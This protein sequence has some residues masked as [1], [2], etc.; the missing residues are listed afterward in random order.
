MRL[1]ISASR[2]QVRWGLAIA[3]AV[4]VAA[5]T[6]VQIAKY[7]YGYRADWTR[8]WN[9]D[10]EWNLPS[11]FSAALL[12]WGAL[13]MDRLGQ[14]PGG[15][16]AWRRLAQF[17]GFLALD[18]WFSIHE[19]LIIPDLAKALNLPGFLRQIWVIPAMALVAALVIKGRRFLAGLPVPLRRTLIGSGLLFFGGAIGLEMVGSAYS[20]LEG[21]QNLTYALMAVLE[22]AMEMTGSAVLG[23][24]LL[25]HLG[26]WSFH[27]EVDASLGTPPPDALGPSPRDRPNP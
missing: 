21:Q 10:R 5:G 1:R 14:R 20:D 2:G 11:F 22:E 12:G 23:L 25:K 3:I 26:H 18:E 24:G 17:L 16:R 27:L 13:L 8:F 19:I 7:S 9:L 15:S 6:A 4:L